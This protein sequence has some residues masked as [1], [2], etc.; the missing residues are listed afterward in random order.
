[1]ADRN[2]K[3]GTYTS[4]SG[5]FLPLTKIF[6]R[7]PGAYGQPLLRTFGFTAFLKLQFVVTEEAYIQI[8]TTDHST[9]FFY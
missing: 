5:G 9:H 2:T 3:P 8:P 1:M 7:L 4:D 6:W